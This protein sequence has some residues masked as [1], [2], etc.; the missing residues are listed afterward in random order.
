MG[1]SKQGSIGEARARDLEFL[2]FV[3]SHNRNDQWTFHLLSYHYSVSV[4]NK[5][6]SFSCGWAE[7]AR[8][9]KVV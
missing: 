8:P 1:L 4:L 6:G 7:S 2:S 3:S 5:T 9:E